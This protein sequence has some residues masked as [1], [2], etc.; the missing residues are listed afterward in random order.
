MQFGNTN[1]LVA[2]PGWEIGLQKTGFINEAGRCLMMQAV[3]EGRAVIMV[4][5]DSKENSRVRPMR[6]ACA[7]GSK[8]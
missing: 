6:D 7:S 5:L 8:H 2:N 3:I 1:H 4:F